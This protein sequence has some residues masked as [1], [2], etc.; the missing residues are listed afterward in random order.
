MLKFLAGA[1]GVFALLAGLAAP[2][3][4]DT[5]TVQAGDTL[6]ALTDGDWA[7]ACVANVAA[8]VIDNCDMI[9]PGDELELDVSAADRARIDRWFA[10]LPAPRQSGASSRRAGA[11]APATPP[12]APPPPAP[13]NPTGSVWDQVAACESGG[14]WAINTGNGYYGGLQFSQSTWEAYG[15]TRYAARA[16]QASRAAQITV[17][18]ATLAGQGWGAWPACS[19]RLGLR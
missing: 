11:Q 6:W 17:A 8:G 9:H 12:P 18:E 14:N 2:A 3:S 5:R 4:A 7:H 13:S 16:D 15:G 1:A 10:A 19:A